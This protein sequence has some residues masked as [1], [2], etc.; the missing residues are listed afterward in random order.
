[1][2]VIVIIHWF[3]VWFRKNPGEV[4]SYSTGRP[5]PFWRYV[6]LG[7]LTV[8]RYIEPLL[9]LGLAFALSKIDQAFAYWIAAASVA[10]FIEEQLSRAS[11]KTRIL[12]AVD[13]RI[14]AQALHQGV[15]RRLTPGSASLPAS[16]V[17]KA[18]KRSKRSSAKL[19]KIIQQLD[20]DLR[21]MVDASNAPQNNHPQ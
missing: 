13:S 20:P 5:L 3:N 4:H 1:M 6:R 14:E 7:E 21:R 11:G 15:Q 17:V 10:A 18:A 16:S 8:K 12:D 19:P 9:C 2:L